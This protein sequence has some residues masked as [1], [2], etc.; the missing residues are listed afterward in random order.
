[1]GPGNRVEGLDFSR[2]LRLP[3]HPCHGYPEASETDLRACRKLGIEHAAVPPEFPSNW[4]KRARAASGY[5]DRD[6]FVS[7]PRKT[8]SRS[9]GPSERRP[10]RTRRCAGRTAAG[11]AARRIT[12]S[13]SGLDAELSLR[14]RCALPDTVISPDKEESAL[15][16]TIGSGPIVL[17]E[18]CL[19]TLA[20]DRAR[21]LGRMTRTS[22][23]GARG[24]RRAARILQLARASLAPA[25]RPGAGR[26]LP[27][28]RLA[29]SLEAAG[30]PTC[31][32]KDRDDPCGRLSTTGSG[33]V[34]PRGHGPLPGPSDRR[35]V[36]D[37]L[38]VEPG[39]Y[40]RSS[41]ACVP[42]ISCSSGRGA[43]VLTDF[44]LSLS[45]VPEHEPLPKRPVPRCVDG[46]ASLPAAFPSL[47]CRKQFK[48]FEH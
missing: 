28:S 2:S 47:E 36:F 32:P 15:G 23:G 11:R 6:R 1:M 41:A 40:R 30:Q 20:A 24:S 12:A 29:W 14:R 21:V 9:R 25:S 19:S 44:P 16:P 7:S 17:F 48:T 33:T 34:S 13:R 45:L 39:C 18:S 31:G 22:A 5:R 8:G 43:E 42:R 46:L 3:S 4:R 37:F 27:E 35:G 38:A 26:G 10:L